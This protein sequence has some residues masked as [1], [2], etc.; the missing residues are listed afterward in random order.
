MLAPFRLGVIA[1]AIRVATGGGGG[2]PETDN[3]ILLAH[4][5]G[6]DNATTFVDSGPNGVTLTGTGSAAL[7]TEQSKFGGSSLGALAAGHVQGSAAGIAFGASGE[8]TVECWAYGNTVSSAA[9]RGPFQV[10]TSSAGPQES[11]TNLAAFVGASGRWSFYLGGIV[12][13]S[14]TNVSANT[15]YH[16]AI[17]RRAGVLRAFVDGALA[18]EAANTYDFSGTGFAIGAY[19]SSAFRWDGYVDD[20]RILSAGIYT[21]AFTPPAAQFPDA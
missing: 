15:W 20:F 10:C 2:D 1:A 16:L 18:Y 8:F 13:N 12:A 6:A 21:A 4:F 7:Q 9:Q 5:N 11:N 17:S 3:L 19:Y 14:G